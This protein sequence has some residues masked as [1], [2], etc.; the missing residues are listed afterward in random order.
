[1][2][3]VELI[4]VDDDRIMKSHT[5]DDVKDAIDKV[6]ELLNQYEGDDN[7]EIIFRDLDVDWKCLVEDI[8]DF[9][10]LCDMY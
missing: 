5:Y 6:Q 1:M 2:F 3:K 8:F 9:T 7:R 4:R 10:T